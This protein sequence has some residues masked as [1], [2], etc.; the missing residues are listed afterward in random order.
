MRFNVLQNKRLGKCQNQKE[1]KSYSAKEL[2]R[3]N[4]AEKLRSR[5]KKATKIEETPE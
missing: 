4:R 5:E 3:C 2:D 1:N